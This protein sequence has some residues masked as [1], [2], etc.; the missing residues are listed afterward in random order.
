MLKRDQVYQDLLERIS[1]GLWQPGDKLPSEPF[2][3]RELGVARVTLRAAM[4]QLADEGF[5]LRSWPA[6]TIVTLPQNKRKKIIVLAQVAEDDC[7]IS[8]GFYISPGIQRRCL[9][10]TWPFWRGF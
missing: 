9:E 10:C 1:N 5:L 8:P 4:R 2:L 6:G 3:C 7:T